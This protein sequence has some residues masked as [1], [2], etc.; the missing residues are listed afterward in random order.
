MELATWGKIYE[1]FGYNPGIDPA[2]YPT[3]GDLSATGK[4]AFTNEM[5]SGQLVPI[6]WIK[7]AAPLPVNHVYTHLNYYSSTQWEIRAGLSR[8]AASTLLVTG[9]LYD[10]FNDNQTS[11]YVTIPTGSYYSNTQYIFATP[12]SNWQLIGTPEVS[13]ASDGTYQY[14]IS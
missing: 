8:P 10:N 6:S 9:E 1:I 12:W 3:V 2:K 5:S 13:P 7:L 14:I 11:W 4:F